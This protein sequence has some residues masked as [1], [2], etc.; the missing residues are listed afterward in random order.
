MPKTGRTHQIRRHLSY[1]LGCSIV[2]DS[3]Y[4]GGGERAR[5]AR[6]MGMFLCANSV[7]FTHELIDKH[8]SIVAKIPVPEKFYTIMGCKNNSKD[9]TLYSLNEF[10]HASTWS[11]MAARRIQDVSLPLLRS[12]LQVAQRGGPHHYNPTYCHSNQ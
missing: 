2:G 9:V 3:K 10:R 12:P 8:T 4:D 6:D 5:S 11:Q 1:C 7:E